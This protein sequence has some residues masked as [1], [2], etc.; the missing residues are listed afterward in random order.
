MPETAEFREFRGQHTQF[1][2]AP[3]PDQT[4]PRPKSGLTKRAM[5]PPPRPPLNCGQPA[6]C[7]AFVSLPCRKFRNSGDRNS[8]DSI[9]NSKPRRLRE[10]A[11]PRIKSGVTKRARRGKS[12][13]GSR[14]RGN[15]EEGAHRPPPPHRF[16]TNSARS[17]RPLMP[18]YLQSISCA[19]PVS[20]IDL[21][22]VP[23]L[24]VLPAPLTR[25]KRLRCR[26]AGP[27]D[28]PGRGGDLHHR[29]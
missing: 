22:S 7:Q 24:S 2:L 8:G 27:G 3:S 6:S 12:K 9:P 21:I 29:K 18:S 13:P 25:G 28:Q 1:P 23:C 14:V 16:F 11:G 10:Q 20:R 26:A 17:T 4:C 15:D 19:S 5:P